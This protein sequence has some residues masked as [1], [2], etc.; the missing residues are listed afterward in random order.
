MIITYLFGLLIQKKMLGLNISGTLTCCVYILLELLQTM[1]L[2]VN[3]IL[4]GYKQYRKYWSPKRNSLN[5][6][7][8]FLEFNLGVFFFHKGIT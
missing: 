4:Y 8:A 1:L 7:I 5:D 2:L 3:H 6:I